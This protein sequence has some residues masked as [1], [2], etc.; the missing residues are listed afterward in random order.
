MRCEPP[1]N[2]MQSRSDPK[3]SF[4]QHAHHGYRRSLANLVDLGSRVGFSIFTDFGKLA[5]YRRPRRQDTFMTNNGHLLRTS[6]I[7][8]EA[9]NV[10]GP[11]HIDYPLG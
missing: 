2:G 8:L 6:R 5:T 3:E 1:R 11:D 7:Q 4:V 10:A 9:S